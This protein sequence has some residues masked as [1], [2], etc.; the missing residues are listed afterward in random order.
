MRKNENKGKWKGILRFSNSCIQV[1]K[2]K[3]LN[4]WLKFLDI[5]DQVFD[6]TTEHSRCEKLHERNAQVL[7]PVKREM[8]VKLENTSFEDK[9]LQ[10]RQV[11]ENFFNY[12]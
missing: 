6:L 9:I 5:V 12:L 1:K 3:L 4:D 8:G 2:L 10:I 11:V 7:A